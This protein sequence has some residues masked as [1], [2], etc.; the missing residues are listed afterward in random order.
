MCPVFLSGGRCADR[1][2]C[3]SKPC[4][5]HIANQLIQV[6]KSV[7]EK[8]EEATK[9]AEKSAEKVANKIEEELQNGPLKINSTAY[10]KRRFAVQYA[11]FF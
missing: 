5:A 9:E 10:C 7:C 4:P 2:Q 1:C 6:K 3:R 11:C 8:P